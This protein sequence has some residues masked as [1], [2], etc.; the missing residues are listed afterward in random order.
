M[1]LEGIFYLTLSAL[2]LGIAASFLSACCQYPF[3]RWLD[4]GASEK[5]SS[6]FWMGLAL[7][8]LFFG[9][10]ISILSVA[11]GWL[12]TVGWIADHCRQHPGHPHLCLRHIGENPPGGYLFWVTLAVVLVALVPPLH[13]SRKALSA[14]REALL[15][16]NS[17]NGAQGAYSVIQ[18]KIPAAFTAGILAP[19]PFFT[20][21]A[22]DVLSP[23]EQAIVVSH[24]R[25]HVRK[26]DPLRL[27]ILTSCGH[28]LP[29]ISLIRRHWQRMAELECDQKAVEAGF[30]AESVAAT[31]VKLKKAGMGQLVQDGCPACDGQDLRF[32]VERLL[33]GHTPTW[34]G[35]PVATGLIGTVSM[36][37]LFFPA[38]HHSL[39]T[40]LGWIAR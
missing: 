22:L 37:I 7:V 3:L 32:R 27:F 34:S 29:G 16:A 17:P 38:V 23:N 40:C 11:S 28:W 36:L 1:N 35:W 4:R 10:L 39:E 19:R 31:I 24:E 2:L 6:T 33:T 15:S 18:S 8:P 30:S 21:G 25:E 26:K 14:W 9:M 13:R 20:Q 5:F 12:S